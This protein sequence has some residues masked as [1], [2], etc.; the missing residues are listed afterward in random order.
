MVLEAIKTL[1]LTLYPFAPHIASEM[2]SNLHPGQ[3]IHETSWPSFDLE[4]TKTEEILIVVQVNGKVRQ[5][6]SV[7]ADIGK[8]DLECRALTD[9]KVKEWIQ[10]KTPRKI[11]VV[12][13]KLVNI[14]V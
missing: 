1:A 12:Q 3:Q 14:V 8:E 13:K 4:L 2:W 6:L 10:D 7:P 11:I 9:D 5:R